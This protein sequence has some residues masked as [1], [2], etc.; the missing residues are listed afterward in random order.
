MGEFLK[1]LDGDIVVRSDE[2]TRANVVD[3]FR[4]A[5]NVQG[6]VP[7]FLE[8]CRDAK[9]Q[10]QTRASP[11]R[12]RVV[13]HLPN[14]AHVAGQYRRVLDRTLRLEKGRPAHEAQLEPVDFV[15]LSLLPQN[16]QAVSPHLRYG[17]VH[18]AY[19]RTVFVTNQPVTMFQEEFARDVSKLV[20]TVV[21]VIHS[22]ARDKG[23]AL[24]DQEVDAEFQLLPRKRPNRPVKLIAAVVV[25]KDFPV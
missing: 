25:E 6:V 15:V 20:T 18:A 12:R 7:A 8:C 24:I 3:E 19:R 10:D 17:V 9:A 23:D 22:N 1:R 16:R 5:G 4:Q 13:E 21:R 11:L 14:L 2:V